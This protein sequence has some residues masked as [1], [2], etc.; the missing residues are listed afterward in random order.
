MRCP[1]TVK[2]LFL[3][4]GRRSDSAANEVPQ[5]ITGKLKDM[6]FNLVQNKEQQQIKYK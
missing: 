1:L 4:S 5:R 6:F 2:A 3:V